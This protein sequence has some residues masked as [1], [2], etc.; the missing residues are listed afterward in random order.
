MIRN[1]M[2][3]FS[4]KTLQQFYIVNIMKK[5]NKKLRS[6]FY[7]IVIIEYMNC[8]V[9]KLS[10]FRYL[11]CFFIFFSSIFAWCKCNRFKLWTRPTPIEIPQFDVK[12]WTTVYIVQFFSKRDIA[13]VII[14]KFNV[15]MKLFIFYS[16][17][18]LF[19]TAITQT[20]FC[21]RERFD[22]IPVSNDVGRWRNPLIIF[23]FWN[24]FIHFVR[25]TGKVIFCLGRPRPLR[26]AV[27]SQIQA[28]QV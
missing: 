25:L 9:V 27:P 19:E 6:F 18:R 24:I 28:F 12:N 15:C 14:R 23:F 7:V 17:Y 5:I 4:I 2:V 1:V 11:K 8:I 26:I 16:R 3:L 10:F 22:S 20:Q 21:Y 13:F